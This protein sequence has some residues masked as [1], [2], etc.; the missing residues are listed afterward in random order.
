M[1]RTALALFLLVSHSLAANYTARRVT[2]EGVDAI[3][4][5]DARNKTEVTIL[6]AVGNMG[7]EMKVNGRNV[8]GTPEGGLAKFAARPT[9]T[10]IPFLA[11]WA[12][13]IDGQAFFANGKKYIFNPNLGNVRGNI[14]MHG[15][16]TTSSA[17]RVV[18]V[19]ADGKAAWATSRLEF[20][21]Y[22]DMMAQFPFAHT[23]EMSYRLAGGAL[24]I[25]TVLRNHS[26]EPM[27][28][29]AG[30]HPYFR[31]YDAPR[32]HWTIHIPARDHWALNSSLLPTGEVRSV[33]LPD[34]TPLAGRAFDDVF[35]GLVR[36]ADGRAEFWLRGEK[37]QVSVLFGPKYTAGVVWAPRQRD[38]VCFEPM[39][40]ITNGWN[41][42][43]AGL[44]KELQ[45]VPAGGE[46]RE[47]FWIRP[48][49]F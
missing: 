37:Q 14:P 39:T 16:L 24:Q 26:A 15:F 22:P 11:P 25:E 7:Y 3:V 31:V 35:S 49:G 27:P 6:P 19:K 33:D 34:P 5:A 8:L 9:M 45:S 4:L 32:D 48:S 46:W 42:A 23:I 12:N 43:H 2:V 10:G 38:V 36:D 28:L 29:A 20:W 21:R 18:E 30:F 41:L 44:Y 40:A 1:Q 13:R 17:W 47:S